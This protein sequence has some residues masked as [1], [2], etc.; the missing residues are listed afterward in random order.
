MTRDP[1]WTFWSAAY[2]MNNPHYIEATKP[3]WYIW[4][5]HFIA[6]RRYLI[7]KKKKY[8]RRYEFW[9]GISN[10]FSF[11]KKP[12]F[13]IFLNCL[14]AWIID[15]KKVQRRMF[16]HVPEWNLCCR[17]LILH[18]DWLKDEDKINAYLPREGFLWQSEVYKDDRLLPLDQEY[19]L[20]KETLWF[21]W[22]E[23]LKR[24]DI[25]I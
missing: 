10:F 19:Y 1:Y 17:Q 9:H 21:V 11:G 22:M 24:H 7:T 25:I 8:K 20:D 6:W 2:I 23:N 5:P 3:P 13:A 15:S 4:R 14:A 12:A 16:K 18:P